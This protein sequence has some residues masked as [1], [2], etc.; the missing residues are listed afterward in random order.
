MTSCSWSKYAI[1]HLEEKPKSVFQSSEVIQEDS[2]SLTFS[3]LLA[4]WCLPISE[5]EFKSKQTLYCL[6]DTFSSK[7]TFGKAYGQTLT[8]IHPSIDSQEDQAQAGLAQALSYSFSSPHW[9]H[10]LA[11]DGILLF[12]GNFFVWF[13]SLEWWG[14]SEKVYSHKSATFFFAN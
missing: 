9:S 6:V 8:D 12:P 11:S 1:D 10:S 4:F 14:R 5:P 2:L 7:W 13:L 3:T